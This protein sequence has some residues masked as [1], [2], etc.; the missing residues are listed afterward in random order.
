MN[1]REFI[2]LSGAGMLASR[3]GHATTPQLRHI[4]CIG[5]SLMIG[6]GGTPSL[7]TSQPFANKVLS[8]GTALTDL[9]AS[10]TCGVNSN[11]EPP[12]PGIVN[13][14]RS[15]AGSGFGDYVVTQAG[16]GSSAY[17]NLEKGTTPYNNSITNAGLLPGAAGGAGK[18]YD[19]LAIACIHGESDTGQNNPNYKADLVQWRSDYQGD[20]YAISSQSAASPL[21]FFTDQVFDWNIGNNKSTQPIRSG[22][23]TPALGQWE[24]ARDNPGVFHCVAPLYGRAYQGGANQEHLINSGYLT[25]GELFG[26][27]M[28]RVLALGNPWAGLVPRRIT[29]SGAVVT[30]RFWTYSGAVLV[31]DTTLLSDQGNGKGFEVYDAT[32]D[33]NLTISSVSV[34]GD[35]ATITLSGAPTAGHAIRLRNA[36]TATLDASGGTSGQAHSNIRND[37][38]TVGQLSGETLY[39]WSLMFDEPIGY[40][41]NPSAATNMVISK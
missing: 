28:Y 8:G 27:W 19:F 2:R 6:S 9:V 3:M 33:T 5:Q 15:M 40:Y 36:F 16:L 35:T 22:V 32:A 30:C 34:S 39:D 1:R 37:D 38:A 25:L 4:M 29:I 24:V 10:N 14:L 41:W 11:V 20:L 31:I 26:K 17:A 12:P 7:S 23:R 13:Q 21:R 18:T